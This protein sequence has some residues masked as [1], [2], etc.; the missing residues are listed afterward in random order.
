MRSSNGRRALTSIHTTVLALLVASFTGCSTQQGD[1]H[2]TFAKEGAELVNHCWRVKH[3]WEDRGR[4][5]ASLRREY[6]K[7]RDL[8]ADG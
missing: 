3:E 5:T 7:C 8:A 6:E 2:Q 4:K 1:A